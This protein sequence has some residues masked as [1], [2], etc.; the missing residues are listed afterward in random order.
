[1]HKFIVTIWDQFY[2]HV[3]FTDE[4][5]KARETEKISKMMQ[6]VTDEARF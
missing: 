3:H 2:Y 4:K 1:M 5:T 6:Q